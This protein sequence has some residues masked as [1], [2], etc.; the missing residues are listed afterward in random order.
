MRDKIQAMDDSD[1]NETTDI[2]WS[3][4]DANRTEFSHLNSLDTNL[5]LFK[6]EYDF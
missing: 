3:L 4:L 6:T 1:V 2:D 5:S